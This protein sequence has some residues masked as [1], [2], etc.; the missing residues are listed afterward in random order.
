MTATAPARSSAW[1]DGINRKTAG[2]RAK[3]YR[4]IRAI[5]DARNRL[6]IARLQGENQRLREAIADTERREL[7][8]LAKGATV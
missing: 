3:L 1:S 5:F 4:T 2:R 6:E 7:R 8:V